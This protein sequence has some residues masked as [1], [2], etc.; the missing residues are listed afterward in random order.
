MATSISNQRASF[1]VVEGLDRSGKS[2]QAANLTKKLNDNGHKSKLIKFPGQSLFVLLISLGFLDCFL[3]RDRTTTIGK[4]INAYLQ[5][6][7]DLDDHVI[8]LL[9]SANRWELASQLE[10]DLNSGCNIICDR[11]AFSGCAFSAAKGLPYD[12]CWAP[13]IGLPAPDIVLF[14][15]VSPEVAKSRGGYGEERYEK[16]DLQ[17]RVREVFQHLGKV[18]GPR[19]HTINA[20]QSFE[21]VEKQIWAK[22]DSHISG[23]NTPLA[24]LQ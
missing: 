16:E 14:L 1:I 3:L 4:M 24:R 15:D 23:V 6:H 8:H 18:Y 12:W 5:S 2:T 13:D 22:V 19:W 9:F 11:Y 10:S 20:N 21:E 17:R 7:S